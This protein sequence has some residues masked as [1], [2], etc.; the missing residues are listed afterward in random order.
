MSFPERLTQYEPASLREVA[1]LSFSFILVLFSVSLMGFCDRLLLAHS[2]LEGLEVG[3]TALWLSQLFQIPIIRAAS[4]TQAFVG[5]YK[6]AGQLEKIGPCIWQMI[7]FSLLSMLITWPL[8]EPIGRLF[9][10]QTA[11]QD[12]QRCFRLLMSVNFLFPLG[13]ALS[14]F[15]LGQGKTKR[16]LLT[17]FLSHGLHIVLDF[18]LVFGVPGVLLPLGVFGSVLSAAISQFFFCG[19]LL[20]D[21]LNSKNHITY[22]THQIALKWASFYSYLRVGLPRTVAKLFQLG[23]WIVVAKLM[24]AK[25]EDCA[26]VLAF[27]GTLQ[28][29]LSCSNEGLSQALT[30]IGAYLIGSKQPLIWKAVRSASLFLWLKGLLVAIPLILF[31]ENIVALFIKQDI[32]PALREALILSCLWIWV[33]FLMEGMN[34]I[35]FG[36]LSAY[37]DTVF[38]MRFAGLVWITGCI[39]TYL[40]IYLGNASPD[41]FW[42]I[43]AGACCIAAIIYFIRLRQNKWKVSSNLAEQVVQ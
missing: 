40:V 21:F 35:G 38:Q 37:K 20:L 2:S 5:Q 16:V 9:F 8:S 39:P 13:S 14:A 12:G 17:S 7:W 31:P 18:P 6:G 19:S 23:A 32:S 43:S 3:I 22:G 25:S 15:Y 4:M 1:K 24:I 30:T 10:N 26:V 36:L 11:L 34:L 42:L 29:F 27:G 33:L 28:M 41:L